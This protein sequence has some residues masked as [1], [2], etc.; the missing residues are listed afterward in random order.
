MRLLPD[1][2][3]GL[4]PPED[5]VIRRVLHARGVPDEA[6]V[7]LPGMVA[8][9]QDEACAL[10]HFLDGEP[11]TSV[12]VVTNG[13]H[14][15]RARM[16]FGQELGNRMARVHFVAAPTDDFSAEDWWRREGGVHCYLTEYLKLVYYGLRGDWA[17]QG[18]ALTLVLAAGWLVWRRWQTRKDMT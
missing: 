16:L 7:T 13:F 15:R 14:T 4:A 9:T 6:V 8:S 1:Q 2:A 18:G 5:E 10:A 3:D 17:W 12:A 11:E